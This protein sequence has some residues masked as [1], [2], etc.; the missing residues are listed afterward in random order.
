MSSVFV[1]R[2]GEWKLGGLDYMY[3]AGS[4]ESAPKK[5][6]E[7]EKYNPPEKSDRS[8]TSREKW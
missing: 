4:E 7:L 5:G 2:A 3:P 8:K 6:P 1:D